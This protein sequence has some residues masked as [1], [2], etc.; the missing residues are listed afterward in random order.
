MNLG[1]RLPV[2]SCFQSAQG[3]IR[4]EGVVGIADTFLG[5]RAKARAVLVA[6]WVIDGDAT[7]SYM[8]LFYNRLYQNM[9]VDDQLWKVSKCALFYIIGDDIQFSNDEV[10]KIRER[11]FAF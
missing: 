4:A 11:A 9:Q 5:A 3:D 7:P 10:N 6:L 1:A 2:L 8:E